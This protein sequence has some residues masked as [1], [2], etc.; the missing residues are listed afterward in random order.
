MCLNFYDDFPMIEPEATAA[1]A[2]TASQT[3]LRLLGWQ[4]SD[5]PSKSLPFSAV[6]SALGV[7]FDL[8]RSDEHLAFV[9]NEVS[10]LESIKQQILGIIQH[11]CIS[12]TQISSLRG[13]LQYTERQ[14]FG[15]VG[16]G[17]LDKFNRKSR[18]F[19]GKRMDPE[20]AGNLLNIIYWLMTAKPRRVRPDH[21]SPP[22]LIFTDGAEGDICGAEAACGALMV[23]PAD[24]AREYFGEAIPTSLINQWKSG[25][26]KKIIALAELLPILIAKQ[27]WGERLGNK[28][29]VIFVDNEGAKFSCIRMA[30]EE[31][32]S[33]KILM[34]ITQ[35]E[36][37]NQSWTW[38]TRV[39]TYSNP[40]DPASRL[41]HDTMRKVFLAKRIG[42]SLPE[43]M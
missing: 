29:V 35:E 25:G 10:R 24:G 40:A 16:A 3:Y 9:S 18:Q 8:S 38:Y 14:V 33:T 5:D 32:N 31:L 15:R 20:L 28:R 30:S 12:D 42:V 13:K 7:V 23:D 43:K 6:F 22:V 27:V 4:F 26:L 41:D 34:M 39:P 19:A 17:L 1:L 2:Q 37:K 21:E 36:L 11:G